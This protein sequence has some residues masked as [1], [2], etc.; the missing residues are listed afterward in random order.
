MSQTNPPVNPANRVS[1]VAGKP[2]APQPPAA[3]AVLGSPVRPQQPGE[4]KP[5]INFWQTRVAQDVVPFVTS[6]LLHSIIII[7]ALILV[8]KIAKNLNPDQHKEETI[9]PDVSL[10]TDDNIGGVPHPGMGGDPTRDAA[11]ENDPNQKE[12]QG[13][14]Q[15]QTGQIN[16]DDSAGGDSGSLIQRGVGN[17]PG[18]GTG[19]G[20]PFGG[21][22]GEAKF[23]PRGGGGGVGP[24]SKLVG[25]GGNVLTV[26]FVCDA[27]G[28]MLQSG[29][30]EILK[31]ELKHEI[32]RMKAIQQFNIIFFQKDEE[33]KTGYIAFR[34]NMVPANSGNQRAVETFLEGVP[35]RGPTFPIAALDEAYREGPQ[36]I[37]FLTDGEFNDGIGGFG[38]PTD[39]EMLAYFRAK[40]KERDKEHRVHV[41]TVLLLRQQQEAAD[42][43]NVT[44]TL[45][46]VA[47]ENGGVFK[48]RTADDF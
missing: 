2:A 12:S 15:H 26:V 48:A 39:D 33:N 43:T 45:N 10:A 9:V 19:A 25:T 11:Q 23:G 44:K 1:P 7:L 6:V 38:G 14:S 40:S 32:G 41:N 34:P 24:P 22:G 13:L 36:L 27:T 3:P 5:H 4:L 16:L 21:N 46:T 37:Y 29:K 18:R 28:S 8:P 42:M 17:G 31:N 20:D 30:F 35:A 47:N